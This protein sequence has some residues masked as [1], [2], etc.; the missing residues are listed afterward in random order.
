MMVAILLTYLNDNSVLVRRK[1]HCKQFQQAGR[2]VYRAE[3]CDHAQIVQVYQAN[4]SA[5]TG[6]GT[7]CPQGSE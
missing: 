7:S 1:L 2:S 4:Q 5:G 3:R 6:S